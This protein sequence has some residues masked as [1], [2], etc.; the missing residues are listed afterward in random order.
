MYACAR[1]DR[2]PIPWADS[3]SPPLLLCIELLFF[4]L[5]LLVLFFFCFDEKRRESQINKSN[6]KELSEQRFFFFCVR[7]RKRKCQRS[8]ASLLF[9]SSIIHCNSCTFYAISSLFSVGGSRRVNRI[10]FSTVRLH[11]LYRSRYVDPRL[12]SLIQQF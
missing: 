6:R 5:P 3:G 8:G 12:R 10:F 2:R 4:L 11:L 7:Q 1:V 9:F